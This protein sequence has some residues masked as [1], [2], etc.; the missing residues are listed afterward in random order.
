M[1]C[2]LQAKELRASLKLGMFPLIPRVL[3]TDYNRGTIIPIKDCSDE[4][5]HPS[6]KPLPLQPEALGA[7]LSQPE[8]PE[9]LNVRVP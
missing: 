6:P 2:F 8:T 7:N 4:E 3:N 1:R 9:L 5:E